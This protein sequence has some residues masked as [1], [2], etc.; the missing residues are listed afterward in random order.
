[1]YTCTANDFRTM[2]LEKKKAARQRNKN[3]RKMITL[4]IVTI[5]IVISGSFLM[6]GQAEASATEMLTYMVQPGDTLW[7]IAGQYNPK[8][9][10]IRETVFY[11]KEA[12]ALKSSLIQPG[13]TLQIPGK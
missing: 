13:Q 7:T 8:G 2:R 11:I 9:K 6:A 12:N 1:M 5:I 4:S 10:D 3:L